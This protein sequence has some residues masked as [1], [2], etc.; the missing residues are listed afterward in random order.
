MLRETLNQGA[1]DHYDGAPHDGPTA[2]K[3]VV[4]NGDKGQGQ[5]GAQRVGSGDDALE[6]ALGVVKI[7]NAVSNGE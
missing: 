3:F 2:T 6:G 7:C 1:D 4:D 5:N